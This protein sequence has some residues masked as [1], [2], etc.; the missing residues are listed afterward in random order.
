MFLEALY[1]C[2]RGGVR[3]IVLATS[4]DYPCECIDAMAGTARQSVVLA[5]WEA[6]PP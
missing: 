1:K 5:T 3:I 2:S 6:K 4:S